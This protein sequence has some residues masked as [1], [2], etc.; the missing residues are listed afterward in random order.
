[1]SHEKK[2][3]DLMARLTSMSPEPPP[4]PEETPMARHQEPS[5]RRPALVFVGA[6]VLV[7]ALAVPLLLFT[8]G[9]DPDVIAST[10]STTVPVTTTTAGPTT[11]TEGE[12]ST[13]VAALPAWS[14]PGLFLY[15]SPESSF[16]GNPAL[17]PVILEV[18][19]MD[20]DIVFTDALAAL[21][22]NLPAGLANAIPA[23]V[24]VLSTQTDGQAIV[25][26]MN[27]AFLDGAGGLLADMTM[28]NQLIYT[29]T[30]SD[31]DASV[32]FTVNGQP[33]ETFGSE[34]L[35]LTEPVGRDDFLD[36]LHVINVTQPIVETEDGWIV[37]GLANVFEASLVLHVVDVEGNVTHEE[38]VTATC[39]TGCWGE[40]SAVVDSNL[41]TPGESSIKLFQYSA[42]DGSP[43][44]VITVA[45]PPEGIWRTSLND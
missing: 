8:G 11:T 36:Q 32:L 21:G 44:D 30:Y 20:P 23:S 15:Q 5:R 6:A 12:P 43:V 33:V 26:D 14:H 45:I 2:M 38:F 9:G 18:D 27:E 35:I 22:T 29:L 3:K 10:T 19:S 17:V 39:G 31:P 13:T 37:T 24:S 7:I 4:Y 16:G 34:G 42:E 40:F 28:L 41:I 1:M 25:A